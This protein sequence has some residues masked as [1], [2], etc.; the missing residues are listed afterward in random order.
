MTTIWIFARTLGYPEGGGH[1]W[2]YLNWAL[3]FKECGCR[4]VWLE[5]VGRE[6]ETH[7]IRAK[8]HQLRQKL[9][10]YGLSATALCGGDGKP[11]PEESDLNV[12]PLS[13]ARDADLLVNLSYEA[14]EALLSRFRCSSMIDID[15]GL[16]QVW[17]SSGHLSLPRC[18]YYFTIGETVGTPSALFPDCGVRWVFTPPCVSL[19]FW[20]VRP[21]PENERFTTVSHWYAREWI[22]DGESGYDNSKRAG[23]L[24]CLSLPRRTKAKLELALNLG[25]DE[26]ERAELERLG[27]SVV[28]SG[29][30]ASTPEDYQAYIQ[31]SRAEFSCVKPSCVRLQNAWISDRTLCYLASGRPAVIENT[32]PSALLPDAKG[33][34]RFRDIDEAVERLH[35]VETDYSLHACAARSLAEEHFDAKK[36][37]GKLLRHVMGTSDSGAASRS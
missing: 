23:F 10:R 16:T 21:V 4:V 11:L 5:M 20:P 33:L 15:P 29:R 37:A 17:V 12:V 7:I 19:Q 9:A 3:G 8:L 22:G 32:G 35:A 34:L 2:V 27:W 30:V 1:F 28:D 13:S 25:G 14:P 26:E 36:V 6:R 18:D 31:S 24:P